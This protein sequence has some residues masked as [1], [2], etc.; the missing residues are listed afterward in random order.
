MNMAW[1]ELGKTVRNCDDRFA[2]LAVGHASGT[3]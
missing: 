2:E 3:P 1:D